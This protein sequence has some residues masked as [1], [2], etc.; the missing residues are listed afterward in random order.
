ML[1]RNLDKNLVVV[2]GQQSRIFLLDSFIE[3]LDGTDL[4]I[5]L[6]SIVESFR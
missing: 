6:K 4:F 5:P 1:Y 3:L 2:E